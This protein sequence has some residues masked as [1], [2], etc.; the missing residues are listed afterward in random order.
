MEVVEGKPLDRIVRDKQTSLTDK[1]RIIDQVCAAVGHGH[2]RGIAFAEL[3]GT[4]VYVQ[5]GNHVKV[6]NFGVEYALCSCSVPRRMIVFNPYW[7]PEMLRTEDRQRFDKRSDIFS[8]GVLLYYV[9]TGKYPFG[10]PCVE[11]ILRALHEPHTPLSA[12]LTPYPRALDGILDRAL[13][14]NPD[15]RYATAEEFAVDIDSVITEMEKD[16]VRG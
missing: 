2:Q 9:L 6:L 5:A 4:D 3:M 1:L 11:L 8:I 16:S 7:S 12:W 15:D 10:L 13:A 14:K